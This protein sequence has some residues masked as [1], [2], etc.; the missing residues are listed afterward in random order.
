MAEELGKVDA[1][2]LVQLHTNVKRKVNELRRLECEAEGI[3]DDA[4]FL[5]DVINSRNSRDKRIRSS[6]AHPREGF[7]K[8]FETLSNYLVLLRRTN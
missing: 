7:W 6:F 5:E 2:K 4:F 1:K 3:A 8:A